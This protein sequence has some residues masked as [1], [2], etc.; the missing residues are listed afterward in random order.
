VLVASVRPGRP[1]I[2]L[3]TSVDLAQVSTKSILVIE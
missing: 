1:A 2:P 3:S